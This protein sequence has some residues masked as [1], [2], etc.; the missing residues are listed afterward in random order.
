MVLVSGRPIKTVYRESGLLRLH[1]DPHLGE[2]IAKKHYGN[3]VVLLCV[4][5]AGNPDVSGT[6]GNNQRVGHTIAKSK[7]ERCTSPNFA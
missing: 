2:G 5:L 1:V 6:Y 3:A 7:R 4:L